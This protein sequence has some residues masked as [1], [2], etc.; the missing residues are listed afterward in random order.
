MDV[1]THHPL[2]LRGLSLIQVDWSRRCLSHCFEFG[3]RLPILGELPDGEAAK[4]ARLRMD[5]KYALHQSLTWRGFHYLD[6][7]NFRKRLLEHEKERLVFD[8][9]LQWVKSH[10]FARKAESILSM[11]KGSRALSRCYPLDTLA[12]VYLSLVR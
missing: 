6:L 11:S 9:V 1:H 8:K 4:Q 3:D 12:P 7:C 10:G 5:W 2:P